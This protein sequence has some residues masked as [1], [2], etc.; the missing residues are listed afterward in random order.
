MNTNIIETVNRK[1]LLKIIQRIPAGVPA[2][3]DKITFAVGG[4]MYIGFSDITP[5][6]LVVVSSQ[7]QRVIDCRTGDKIFC[8]ENYDEMELTA[9]ADVLG[10]EIVPLSGEGG[11]GLRRYS[12][13]GN[14]LTSAAPFWPKEKI[15]F[16]PDYISWTQNPEKCTVIFEEYEIKAFGFS[17][18]GNYMAVCNSDTLDIFRK[19]QQTICT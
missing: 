4:L 6:K 8:E 11:G 5:E 9:L 1:R 7:G 16:M 15:I 3:W 12:Q 17:K 18:C 10:D 14:I 13:G 19:I 2:G